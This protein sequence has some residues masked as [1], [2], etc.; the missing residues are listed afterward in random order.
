MVRAWVTLAGFFF[1]EDHILLGRAARLDLS[2]DLLGFRVEGWPAP[3]AAV[4]TW[5]IERTSGASFF[6]PSALLLAAQVAVLVGAARLLLRLLGHRWASTAAI[7]VVSL[8]AVSATVSAWWSGGL[9]SLPAQ[10]GMLVGLGAVERAGPTGR[11]RAGGVVLLATACAL[12]FSPQA[13]LIPV[14]SL[15][16]AVV[17]RHRQPVRSVLRGWWWSAWASWLGLGALIAAYL[18][19]SI[20]LGRDALPKV[21]VAGTVEL[22]GRGIVTA[23]APSMAGGPWAW[24]PVGDGTAIATPPLVLT[25][26]ALQAIAVLVVAS[27]WAS[28]RARRAWAWAA[29]VT[30]F[31]LLL[32][33]WG[34]VVPGVQVGL[35]PVLRYPVEA[36]LPLAIATGYASIG[37][38]PLLSRAVGWFTASTG[39]SGLRPRVPA[40]VAAA[41]LAV[42]GVGASVSTAGYRDIWR[43]SPSRDVMLSAQAAVRDAG[44]E[45]VVLD[46]A[47]SEVV[48][49]PLAFPY[50]QV[51]WAMAPLEPAPVV[52]QW[53]PELLVFDEAGEL[54]DGFVDGPVSTP[55]RGTCL[56]VEGTEPVRFRLTGDVSPLADTVQV[57]Y[58]APRPGTVRVSFGGKD[59]VEVTLQTGRH[60]AFVRLTGARPVLELGGVE[61]D[62]V[63][64]VARVVV[65]EL[66]P[67]PAIA[68]VAP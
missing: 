18:G 13:L 6:L 9:A 37:V 24:A 60:S 67:V 61:Q 23:I 43:V 36:L 14:A 31:S 5:A 1:A 26:L 45:L 20:W 63:A 30:V 12:A 41:V 21:D 50:N 62:A 32:A 64:C 40:A 44:P 27:C 25:I 33:S 48:L 11:A 35:L 49:P 39:S 7:A 10:L 4:V 57:E 68:E 17:L 46:H 52:G 42:V 58:A 54:V 22:V 56:R 66:R 3:A 53:T 59:A 15:G 28:A 55:R 16:L 38:G 2:W 51:S 47:V 8:A 29:T 65:G 19:W 34:R